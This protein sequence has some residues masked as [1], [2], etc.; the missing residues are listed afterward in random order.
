MA[1]QFRVHVDAKQVQRAL[2]RAE[3]REIKKAERAAA[4]SVGALATRTAKAEAPA[5][6]RKYIKNRGVKT[7]RGELTAGAAATGPAVMATT[8]TK[9][10]STRSGAGRGREEALRFM[11]KAADKVDPAAQALYSERMRA[12]LRASGL[13]VEG[14][15]R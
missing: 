7:R 5:K 10:R 4:R 8:G 3:R 9:E 11:D 2:E 6:Y 12:A 13:H 1:D 15:T 14:S